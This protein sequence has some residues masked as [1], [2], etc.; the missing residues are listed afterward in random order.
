MVLKPGSRPK[1]VS[2]TQDDNTSSIG[3]CV[4]CWLVVLFTKEC[5]G[6][7]TG[8]TYRWVYGTLHWTVT[9]AM[10]SSARE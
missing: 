6:V 2:V 7:D 9:C 8:M 1:D 4:S 10:T 5:Q 3:R